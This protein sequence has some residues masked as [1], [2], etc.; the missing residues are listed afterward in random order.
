MIRDLRL[1]DRRL[2]LVSFYT[3]DIAARHR[4]PSPRASGQ[5]AG[6]MGLSGTIVWTVLLLPAISAGSDADQTTRVRPFG[7]RLQYAVQHGMRRSATFERLVRDLESSQLFVYIQAGRCLNRTATGC[8]VFQGANAGQRYVRILV[9]DAQ[10][11]DRLIAVLAHE[12]QH[13]REVS[14]APTVIDEASFAAL[15]RNIGRKARDAVYETPEAGEVER[16]AAWEL[17]ANG[18]GPVAARTATSQ[19]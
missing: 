13:A 16:R 15:F 7:K 9:N 18:A 12:L 11:T 2:P 19:R 1:C 4:H 17:R 6:G 10:P 3:G 5:K 14:R 8:L